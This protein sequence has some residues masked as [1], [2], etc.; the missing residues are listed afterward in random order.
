[1]TTSDPNS[2]VQLGEDP[3]HRPLL[4]EGAGEVAL[5][6]SAEQLIG[7][8]HPAGLRVLLGVAQRRLLSHGT[9][10]GVADGVL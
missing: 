10:Y 2:A 9:V 7:D 3:R 5:A 8:V 6:P 1:M 4:V